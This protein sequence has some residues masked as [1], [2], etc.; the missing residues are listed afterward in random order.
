ML[1][2]SEKKAIFFILT[3]I[4]LY[5]CHND[6]LYS[7]WRPHFPNAF[8]TRNDVELRIAAKKDTI[9][10]KNGKPA[11][12]AYSA[13]IKGE[14]LHVQDTIVQYGHVWSTTN[15]LPIIGDD[16]T[17]YSRY[18]NW[19]FDSIGIFTSRISLMPETPFWVRAYVITSRGDT[20]YLPVSYTDTTIPPINEWFI[21]NDLGLL[22]RAEAAAFT[23]IDPSKGYKCGF[24]VGGRDNTGNFGDMWEYDPK[25]QTWTQQPGE[26]PLH[27]KNHVAF[28][29]TRRD[30]N[31]R[32]HY[33]IYAG[34]G[35]NLDGTVKY[36]NFYK[37]SF[38]DGQWHA[39]TPFPSAVAGA[40]AF[41][42]NNRAFVGTGQNQN[43]TDVGYFFEFHPELLDSSGA[44]VWK[45]VTEIGGDGE[46]YRR[47]NAVAF[48]I[49]NT[50]FVGTG[51]KNVNGQTTYYNDLWLF[52]PPEK[53]SQA[54]WIKRQNMPGNPRTGAVG[55]NIED[56][57]YVGL[58]YDGQNLLKDLYRY[59]PYTDKWYPIADY[60]IGP[61]YTGQI[62]RIKDAVG[63]GIE[64]KG[65]VGTGY[66]GD[67][68]AIVYSKEFW[69]YRPW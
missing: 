50:A 65:Y 22:G 29:I 27:L 47:H 44:I 17:L 6:T 13:I 45:S 69:I 12:T 53:N 67:T 39:I 38:I 25:T 49:N 61:Q 48:V 7:V 30:N 36:N 40:V 11:I 28:G 10:I 2:M 8:Y 60:K 14:F 62:Q 31:G 56:Q 63:F 32:L 21:T 59:D 33:E 26:L 20:G 34:T 37:Y 35:E 66:Q 15:P 68:S 24:V 43:G 54:L 1:K 19:P 4:L 41:V 64:N 5:S 42:I 9:L 57:G 55:F 52:I 16:T 18:Y 58:G 51:E 46:K 23:F 3:F